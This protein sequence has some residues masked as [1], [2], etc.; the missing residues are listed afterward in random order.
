LKKSQDYLLNNSQSNIK[1]IIQ[2][3]FSVHIQ[4]LN[5][6]LL[7]QQQ[8]IF[9]LAKT[10][11]IIQLL[12]IVLSTNIEYTDKINLFQQLIWLAEKFSFGSLSYK[13]FFQFQYVFFYNLNATHH[14][15]FN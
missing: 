3:I 5:I 2:Y 11:K 14:H 8:I 4:I 7:F 15:Y 6:Q 12:Q 13:I 9:L 1:V 10:K